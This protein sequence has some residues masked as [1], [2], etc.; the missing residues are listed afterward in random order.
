MTQLVK[1]CLHVLPWR[2]PSMVEVAA[3][4]R[5]VAARAV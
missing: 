5:L 4:L 1:D 3:R 2:R